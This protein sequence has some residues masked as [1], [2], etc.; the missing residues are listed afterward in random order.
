[1]VKVGS[2]P[3]FDLLPQRCQLRRSVT[4]K[5]SQLQSS[6]AAAK[7]LS[8]SIKMFTASAGVRAGEILQRPMQRPPS[9][10]AIKVIHSFKVHNMQSSVLIHEQ[11]RRAPHAVRQ[12]GVHVE[13]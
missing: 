7:S 9:A 3:L 8:Q 4:P 6:A 2:I 11:I 12:R 5:L 10:G 13:R 1:M